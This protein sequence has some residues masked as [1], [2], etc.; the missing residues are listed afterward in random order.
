MSIFNLKA[1]NPDK[2]QK[3]V[4]KELNNDQPRWGYPKFI[5]ID[6]LKNDGFIKD[7]KIK[8]EVHIK[9]DAVT[10]SS[11]DEVLENC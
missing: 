6:E 5:T 7:D 9:V 2:T 11:Q 10:L 4:N 8:I 3:R 1:I